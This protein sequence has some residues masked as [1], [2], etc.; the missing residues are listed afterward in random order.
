MHRATIRILLEVGA[1]AL[2]VC[3]LLIGALF[4]RLDAGPI[5]L[6]FL[7]PYLE[8]AL[9][10]V[11]SPTSVRVTDTVLTWDASRRT[12]DVR[13][14]GINLVDRDGITRAHVP[15]ASMSL[16][17]RA[18]VR[19]IVAPARIDVIGASLSVRRLDDSHFDWGIELDEA[20]PVAG[21]GA[22]SRLLANLLAPPDPTSASGYLTELSI[23]S[24][25]LSVEDERTGS[26]WHTRDTDIVFR[27]DGSGVRAATV[28]AVESNGLRGRVSVSGTYASE[29]HRLQLHLAFPSVDPK[30]L[31][32]VEP[33]LAEVGRFDAR[34]SGRLDLSIDSQGTTYGGSFNLVGSAGAISVPEYYDAPIAFRQ[35]R[36]IGRI[37]QNGDRIVVDE[38]SADFGGPT[39]HASAV[40]DRDAQDAWRISFD[41]RA[42]DVP[43]EAVPGYWPRGVKPNTRGWMERNLQDVIVDEATL[44]LDAVVTASDL[45]VVEVTNIGGG[46][47]FRD[48]T[49]HYLRPMSPVYA[50]SGRAEF[51]HSHFVIR[52]LSGELGNLRLEAATVDIVDLDRPR[53]FANITLT[54]DGPVPDALRLVDE[55]PLGYSTALG[56]DPQDADG[57][58]ST[59]LRLRVP[60]ISTLKLRDVQVE[61]SSELVDFVLADALAGNP[62]TEGKVALEVNGGGLSAEGSL[63]LGDT[64]VAGTWERNFGPESEFVNQFRVSGVAD[65]DARA[66]LGLPF[67][68]HVRGSVGVGL[69]YTMYESGISTGAMQLDLTAATIDIPALDWQKPPATAVDGYAEIIVQG[70]HL[71]RVPIFDVRGEDLVAT[72]SILLGDPPG[73]SLQRISLQRLQLADNDLFGSISFRDGGGFDALIGGGQVDLRPFIESRDDDE[74]EPGSAAGAGLPF[75]VRSSPQS[76]I[77]QVI[78][79]DGIV[80]SNV[81][82]LLGHDGV[83]WR[84]IDV[85]AEVRGGGNLAAE[86]TEVDGVRGVRVTSDNAGDVIRGLGWY[87][88]IEGGALEVNGTFETGETDEIFVGVIDV[89]D[90]MLHEAPL[91]AQLLTLSS[92]TG[93]RNTLSGTGMAFSSLEVPI[94]VSASQV[95]I[96][97][98]RIRGSDLGITVS[99][100]IDRLEDTLAISGE[101]A[102]AYL[103]NSLV[104]RIPILGRIILGG[105]EGLFVATYRING[106]FE[107]PTVTV[108]PL[109]I[110]T[111]GIAR[112][113]IN[114]I[115]KPT[116]FDGEMPDGGSR[117]DD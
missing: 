115:G 65:D 113:I 53:Q 99:G 28:L 116:P 58:Q 56:I 15:A 107:A 50:V 27:R 96:D 33:M 67:A 46:I 20:A 43:I 48:G 108:N 72:G 100:T 60:M 1:A 45:S 47:D 111:P 94:A 102:P 85:R 69:T 40:A 84:Q 97:D 13:A 103:L 37:E 59:K 68:Q 54:V 31:V 112:G 23:R 38:A 49:V 51:D 17:V 78:I 86:L 73:G 10:P 90:F 24:A 26:E 110:L 21:G 81:S 25:R 11:D 76:A 14:L 82:G 44:R 7:T 117:E 34:L 41:G 83:G 30:L 88:H 61:A 62:I 18:L 3:M 42:M 4:W 105:Q 8:A 22:G 114:N 77:E 80:L 91:L 64:P 87:P 5:R 32:Q 57:Q 92:F 106:A 52:S 93:I 101:L 2:L 66:Q 71:T 89:R 95:N 109:T 39:L 36:L 29:S 35:V 55:Q 9:N 12:V 98:A 19:G 63:L 74:G 75:S 6:A 104:G 70:G 79:R 16:S